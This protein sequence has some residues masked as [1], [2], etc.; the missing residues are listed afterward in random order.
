MLR[1]SGDEGAEGL[2]RPHATVPRSAGAPRRAMRSDPG[3]EPAEGKTEA[4]AGASTTY[5]CE[6][7]F[8]APFA[9]LVLHERTCATKTTNALADGLQA[10]PARGTPRLYLCQWK[11]GYAPP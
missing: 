1:D 6:C 11:C 3:R 4:A 2:R 9:E 8:S 10:N 5:A 7:G